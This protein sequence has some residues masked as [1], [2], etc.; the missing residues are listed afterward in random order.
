MVCPQAITQLNIAPQMEDHLFYLL[1][2]SF[3]ALQKAAYIL[4]KFLFENFVP[5][6]LFASDDE[7]DLKNLMSK[8]ESE[9]VQSI[10]YK[11]ISPNLLRLIDE[12]P[13]TNDDDEQ[14]KDAFN[15][16]S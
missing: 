11:N 15:V 3:E 5:P 6:V 2:C 1:G 10:A 16:Q 9:K 7:A 13:S 4:L 14:I 8:N 12:A